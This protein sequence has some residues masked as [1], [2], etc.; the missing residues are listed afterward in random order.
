MLRISLPPEQR[1]EIREEVK[2]ED[3]RAS[4]RRH[5]D[6]S[7]GKTFKGTSRN[8]VERG[9]MSRINALESII[10]LQIK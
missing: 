1:E 5:G 7:T 8:G 3:W 2:G 9:D 6:D 10:L 4:R